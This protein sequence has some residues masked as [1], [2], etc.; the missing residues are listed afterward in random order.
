MARNYFY[1]KL[2]EAAN[3]ASEY[4]D[5]TFIKEFISDTEEYNNPE[6]ADELT[7]IFEEYNNTHSDI[8]YYY[9]AWEVIKKF[10]EDN[11]DYDLSELRDICAEYSI[12]LNTSG[13]EMI[14]TILAIHEHHE[15]WQHVIDYLN[16]LL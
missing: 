8:I 2:E 13:T 1:S 4:Y 10:V 16:E 9:N 11:N 6:D 3:N 7:D 12:D 14:A 5:M 15:A